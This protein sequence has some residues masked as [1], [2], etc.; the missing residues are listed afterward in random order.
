[1]IIVAVTTTAEEPTTPPAA[2]A[3]ACATPADLPSPEALPRLQTIDPP[4]MFSGERVK[5]AEEWNRLHRDGRWDIICVYLPRIAAASCRF[6]T[7]AWS[8]C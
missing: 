3:Q 2:T 7:E 1:M 8:L 4:V 5:T 6:E